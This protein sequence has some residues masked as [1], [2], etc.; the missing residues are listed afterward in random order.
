MLAKIKI[1]WVDI[2]IVKTLMY[3]INCYKECQVRNASQLKYLLS[4][5]KKVTAFLLVEMCYQ[6]HFISLV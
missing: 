2:A 6:N 4:F 3:S 5:E 1:L